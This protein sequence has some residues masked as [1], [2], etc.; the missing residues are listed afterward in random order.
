M[1]KIFKKLGVASWDLADSC[2]EVGLREQWAFLLPLDFSALIFHLPSLYDWR[3]QTYDFPDYIAI[4]H[5][6]C[7]FVFSIQIISKS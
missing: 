7:P 1:A 5:L 2:H 3:Q 4:N 6:C